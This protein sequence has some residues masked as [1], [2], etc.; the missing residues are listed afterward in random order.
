MLSSIVSASPVVIQFVVSRCFESDDFANA[1]FIFE[2]CALLVP[3][4]LACWRWS[5]GCPTSFRIHFGAL[6]THSRLVLL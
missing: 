2:L 3:V 5:Q 1:F 4:G 6:L